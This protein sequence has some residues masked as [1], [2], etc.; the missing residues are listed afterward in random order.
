MAVRDGKQAIEFQERN[1]THIPLALSL[2][3]ALD[4]FP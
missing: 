3:D 1:L 4:T 2:R